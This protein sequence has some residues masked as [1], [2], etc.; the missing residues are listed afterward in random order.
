MCKFSDAQLGWM[1]RHCGGN[2]N[3]GCGPAVDIGPDMTVW[4]CFPLSSFHKRSIFEFDCLGDIVNFYRE[5]AQ[6]V[7]IEVAGIFDECD[8]CWHRET[9]RCNGG[10]LAHL[11][12]R[13]QQEAQVRLP[14]V[15][16]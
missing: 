7:R 5:M 16:G 14:E 8:S 1:S 15:Y 11:L 10:C 13:F 2:N 3:F 4:S 9:E 6:K 12:G